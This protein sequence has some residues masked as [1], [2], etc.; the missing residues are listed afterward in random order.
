M[1][2]FT[3]SNFGAFLTLRLDKIKHECTS[4]QC[5]QFK[6]NEHHKISDTEREKGEGSTEYFFDGKKMESKE[7]V[8]DR[9]LNGS[10]ANCAAYICVL[11]NGGLMGT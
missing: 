4:E 3:N 6:G 11:R 5:E 1:H 2:L 9:V 7:A 8:N 10:Y